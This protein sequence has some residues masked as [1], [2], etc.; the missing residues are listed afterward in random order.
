[1][2]AD[3]CVLLLPSLPQ[4]LSRSSLRS[5][6]KPTLAV[7]FPRLVPNTKKATSRLDIAVILDT[8]YDVSQPRAALFPLPSDPPPGDL[9][10]SLSGCSSAIYR[11]RPTWRPRCPDYLDFATSRGGLQSYPSL[12]APYQPF[13]LRLLSQPNHNDSH[14]GI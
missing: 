12:R 14:S 1:M 2:A 10:A 7:L 13:N 3:K 6:Y 9:Y 4:P 11:P 8:S 5:A